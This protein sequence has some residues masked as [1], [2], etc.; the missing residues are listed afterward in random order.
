MKRFIFVFSLFFLNQC[1]TCK[2]DVVFKHQFENCLLVV[3]NTQGGGYIS[4]LRTRASALLCL[5][6]ITGYKGHVDTG[7]EP[8]YCYP[9]ADLMD[10]DLVVWKEWYERNRCN[11]T[12]Q[13][14]D[15]L[16][17]LVGLEHF[18][19]DLTWPMN[20]DNIEKFE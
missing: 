18:Y 14:A 10:I 12:I 5:Y 17:H 19:D 7:N 16:I 1:S 8:H 3:E 20:A 4:T 11:F 13:M 6:A 9:N 2:E 15:S